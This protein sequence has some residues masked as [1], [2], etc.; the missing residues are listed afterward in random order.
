MGQR[1]TRLLGLGVAALAVLAGVLASATGSRAASGNICTTPSLG[2]PPSTPA[3]CVTEVVAPHFTGGP[4]ISFTKFHNEAG[5]GGATATHVAL[6][7]TF[8]GQVAIDAVRVFVAAPGSTNFTSVS[9]T[10]CT[11]QPGPTLVT[12]ES[13]PVGNIAGDGRAKMI[14]GF[15]GTTGGQLKGEAQYGEGGGNPSNPPNDDQVNYDT[16][17][18]GSA[19]AAGG[20]FNSSSGT[21]ISGASSSGQTTS[22]TLGQTTDTTLPCTY[23]DAGVKDKSLGANGNSENSDISF[24]EFPALAAGTFANVTITFPSAVKVNNKTPI[25][26]DTTYTTD[27]NTVPYFTTFITV[28]DCDNKGNI[29]TSSKTKTINIGTP[30]KGETDSSNPIFYDSCVASRNPSTNTV[31]LHVLANPLDQTY[32][33]G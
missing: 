16:L 17:T 7:V 30:P 33:D 32:R 1:R 15:H 25:F 4:A 2:T 18:V 10:S 13:C 5:V 26:E 23:A 22:I 27:P 11:A 28:T 24:V 29:V 8:P 21:F 12:V 31:V 3:T 19:T 14:V 6:S 9:A 20:C